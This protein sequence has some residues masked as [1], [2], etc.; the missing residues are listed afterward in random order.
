MTFEE[1]LAQALGE[2]FEARMKERV[3]VTKKHRFSLSFGLWKHKTLHDLRKKQLDDH[4]TLRKARRTVMCV[5]SAAAVLFVIMGCAVVNTMIGKFSVDD[6]VL[7]NSL[8]DKIYIEKYYCL[9]KEDGWVMTEFNGGSISTTARYEKNDKTVLFGQAISRQ[10]MDQVNTENAAAEPMTI[11]EEN[12]G[13]FIT[14][15]NGDCG[16]YWSYNGYQLSASG[17]LNKKDLVELAYSTK[18]VNF[19]NIFKFICKKQGR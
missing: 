10:D 19:K 18:A 13:F 6:K 9:P 5:F 16:L 4:W 12:D 17:N 3:T 7:C 11:Y 8:P 15:P 2:T 1:K 14:F